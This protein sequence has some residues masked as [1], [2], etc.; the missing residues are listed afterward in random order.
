M[1]TEVLEIRDVKNSPFKVA[2]ISDDKIVVV[3]GKMR[4]DTDFKTLEEAEKWVN[5][6]PWE[7]IGMLTESLFTYLYKNN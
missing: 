6:K 2:K 7:L 3:C 4:Y 1:K 5:K